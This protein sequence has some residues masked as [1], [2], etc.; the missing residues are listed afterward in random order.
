MN[1]DPRQLAFIT[2]RE[3][4][5]REIY[6][7]VALDRSLTK[8]N[9]DKVNRRLLTE[10]VYGCV[11]R[12]RSLDALI[13]RFAQKKSH[14]QPPDLRII[15]HLGFYQLSYLSQ[16]PA[17][18]AV[19]TSVELA[20]KNGLSGL[21]GLVNGVLRQY[22]RQQEQEISTV[23]VL[24]PEDENLLK[25]LGDLYSFPDWILDYWLNQLGLEET[26][27]LCQWFNQ[28][29]TIDLRVN[30]LKIT[31]EIVETELKSAGINVSQIPHLPQAL[32]LSGSIGEIQKL[33]GYQQGWWTIQ[34]SSA[35]WVSYIL[36][37]QP[38]E[39]IID[40]CAAPGGKTTHIAELMQDTGTIIACDRAKSRLKKVQQNQERLQ[41]QSIQTKL[42]D[43]RE[44]SDHDQSSDRVLLDAPCSG[45]GTL[46][47][48]ADARWR[49]T[50]ENVKELSILQAELLEKTA[51]WVKPGG[52][53]VYATCTIHPL[54]NDRI[55]ES[56]LRQHS[57]WE[58][59]IPK[60]PLSGVVTSEEYLKV[61]P[62]QQN[63]DGFFIVRLQKQM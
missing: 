18:A 61:W 55:I 53:L 49:H 34:E 5:R 8:A 35:Q 31:R 9:L 40:A 32:R 12:R 23:T 51:T 7:D 54:E 17:S 11:R 50:P 59:D 44:F 47:R 42:G 15:L 43:I 20:K 2:L 56:F 36:D 27:K 63:M 46:H 52:Y 62:H 1:D 25:K 33:P 28:S 24:D 19:N 13:D 48:R 38:G 4:K 57:D 3:I 6:A 14:Q 26:Q 37:P 16:I 10:L 29:P 41:L 39:I 45:L 58:I 30:S 22:L 60:I 21:S